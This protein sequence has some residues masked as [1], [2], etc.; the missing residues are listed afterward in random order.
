MNME[1]TTCRVASLFEEQTLLASIKD[2]GDLEIYTPCDTA[3][4]LARGLIARVEAPFGGY[5]FELTKAGEDR[6]TKL[7]QGSK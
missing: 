4:F 1:C 7:E 3:S 6:L 5:Y 2:N